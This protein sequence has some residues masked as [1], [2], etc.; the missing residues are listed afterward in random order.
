[1][2]NNNEGQE[3]FQ[4]VQETVSGNESQEEYSNFNASQENLDAT[5]VSSSDQEVEFNP[6]PNQVKRCIIQEKDQPK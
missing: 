6:K 2:F 3:Q 1:M 4:N 5:Y